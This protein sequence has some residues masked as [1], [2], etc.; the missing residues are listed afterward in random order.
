MFST[1][2]MASSTTSPTAMARP[3]STIVLSV[4]P[5]STEHQHGATIDS[6]MAV[7][8]MTAVRHSNRKAMTMSATRTQPMTWRT[9]ELAERQLDEA[10]PGGSAR[11]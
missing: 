1:S 2:M 8:L 11:A 3:A 6:G 5:M 9:A 4:P 7:R 10:W